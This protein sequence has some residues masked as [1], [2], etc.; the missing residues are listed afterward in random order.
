VKIPLPRGR[1]YL[2]ENRQ[3]IG[4]DRI[5]PDSGILILK[6]DPNVREGSGTVRVMNADPD[7]PNFSH[8]TFRLDRENRGLFID[9]A[10][11]VAVVPLWPDGKN[12]GVLVTTPE[13]GPEAL[14]AA[15]TIQRVLLRFPEP[16]N[17]QLEKEVREAVASF[18]RH[19]FHSSYLK[20]KQLL[21][22]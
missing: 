6:V 5:L 4:Y 8:A 21:K 17:A 11:H 10:D 7:S 13:K 2:V 19:D 15:R 9:K 18:E 1:Y 22:R 16:R 14:R 12:L 20:A 3:P